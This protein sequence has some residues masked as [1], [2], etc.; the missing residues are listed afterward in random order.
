LF[1]KRPSVLDNK[2]L[3]VDDQLRRNKDEFKKCLDENAPKEER[4]RV[5]NAREPLLKTQ[6]ALKTCMAEYH[7]YKELSDK[8]EAL[9]AS[10][11]D[12]FD[13]G[14]DTAEDE[15]RLDQVAEQIKTKEAEL[16]GHLAAAGVD[17]LD[18]LK[19][20]NDSIAAPDS[21]A[22]PVVSATQP[23]LKALSKEKANTIPEYHSQ[24]QVIAQT[25]LPPAESRTSTVSTPTVR[26]VTFHTVSG[27]PRPIA[28]ETLRR[29]RPDIAA[30]NSYRETSE[31]SLFID[32]NSYAPVTSDASLALSQSK[33]PMSRSKGPAKTGGIRDYFEDISDD[34]E[35]MLAAVNHLE[36]RTSTAALSRDGHRVRSALSEAS[37]NAGPPRRTRPAAKNV[38]SLQP[39]ASWPAD[40][41]K[42]PWS[43]DVRRAL[44]DRFR[45]TEF[46]P[47]QL[48]AINATLAGK[49]AFVLMP[50]GGGK[51]LCYQLPA[52][53][54]TG[55]TRGITIVISPLLS[56]MNDQVEHLEKLNIRA[57]SF[58]SQSNVPARNAVLEAFN[59]DNPEFFL[60][61]LYVTPEMVV[62]SVPFQEG[63]K[64]LHRKKKLARIVI[65]EAHCVS[66]WGH[67]FRP[68]YQQIGKLRQ[69]FPGV[70]VMA[71]TAT[72]TGNVI[73]DVKHNL[74]MDDCEV[75]SQSFDRPN[76][77][78]E[79]VKRPATF[80]AGMAELIKTKYP[81]QS[82]IIYTLSR[83]SAEATAES[84]VKKH[85][86]KA[87][88]YHAQV[89][90][91]TRAK[92][93]RQWQRGEIQVVVATI[94]FGMGIDKP[95]VRFVI[96]QHMPKNLEGYYQETGRA[97]RDGE[98]A[99]CYLYYAYT[100]LSSLRRMIN[101]DRE[102]AKVPEQKERL[103]A[104]LN[105]MVSYCERRECRRV[106]LLRYFGENI[107]A[108][109]CNKNCDN[110]K[111]GER[112]SE[113]EVQDFTDTAKAILIAVRSTQPVTLGKLVEIL[114]GRNRSK[115][116]GAEGFGLCKGMKNYEIQR[117]A[118]ALHG[119]G[120][121]R[122]QYVVDK[123]KVPL[124]EFWVS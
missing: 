24:S 12:A 112:N 40:Q 75:F 13:N 28:S 27:V 48:E 122:D 71:L 76:L 44:K 83:K 59:E 41:M 10:L 81:G 98:P 64:K 96:H 100:D 39:K 113:V 87:C 22:A 37:G 77:Y 60:Q 63:L 105:Q 117:I 7:S 23:S 102:Y 26:S 4:E 20:P 93:Q 38:P 118:M 92:V 114:T 32:N 116:E 52:V 90:V 15:A 25:Q 65:D 84:L 119:D 66:H 46:R 97:G 104:L 49:D 121:L 120:A 106:Q 109:Q 45:M 82:G 33:T 123:G 57:A 68:D 73:A 72:A 11:T 111:N 19:D 14:L 8:R 78:Y 88:H 69:R 16:I 3:L 103:H 108:S 53:I 55:R 79:V 56:L 110:C 9:V 51:S 89:D 54:N 61:L 29:V 101:E 70:P 91:E 34:D 31:D 36:Q 2:I 67:D 86:I 115:Y 1:L 107:D 50:T 124:T 94:A 95:D 99:G 30:G 62:K 6:K 21:P 17:D 5:K 58:N 43:S 42:Y 80:V 35:A 18:F 74:D 47:N 85:D